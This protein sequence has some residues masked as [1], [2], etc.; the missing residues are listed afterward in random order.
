M[1]EIDA[2]ATAAVAAV[3][4]YIQSEEEAVVQAGIEAQAAPAP[5]ARPA[6]PVKPWGISGRQAQ[7]QLRSLM[8][9]KAFHGP[10]FR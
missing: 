5:A 9:L 7:M 1:S 4:Y 6:A 8:E 3:M 10:K 2:K